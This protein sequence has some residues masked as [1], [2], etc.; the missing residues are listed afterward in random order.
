MWT[1]DNDVR[2]EPTLFG[3]AD[4][5][6]DA[7]VQE[8]EQDAFEP[9]DGPRLTLVVLDDDELND[10]P[11][12]LLIDTEPPE[13]PVAEDRPANRMKGFLEWADEAFECCAEDDQAV[14][15][16]VANDVAAEDVSP[17]PEP[18]LPQA[19]APAPDSVEPAAEESLAADPPQS[20]GEGRLVA[21]ATAAPDVD[22]MRWRARDVSFQWSF[23]WKVAGATAACGTVVILILKGVFA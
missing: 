9:G 11:K 4:A 14:E 20:V 19:Q 17:D 3:L 10:Q 23:M 5:R 22:L 13:E 16:V 15:P 21:P 6:D 1:R 2:N 7:D 12:L 18:L 8:D